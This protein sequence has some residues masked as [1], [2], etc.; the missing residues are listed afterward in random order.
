MT[1]YRDSHLARGE[2]YD[3]TLAGAPF[4]HYMAK[5]ERDYLL[6]TVPGLFPRGRP[7]Y[8]DFA[9]GTGRITQTV[10]PLAGEAI[11]VDISSSMLREAQRK[12][13]TVRFV[14]ADLTKAEVDLGIF[15]MITSF[16]F[17]GNAQDEL[18]VSVMRTLNRLLRPGGY[19][20]INSHRNPHSI[21]DILQRIGNANQGMD[22]HYFK[23]KRLLRKHG[24][25]IVKTRPIGA[26][27]YR[28]KLMDASYD[29]A[30]TKRLESMFTS[31]MFTPI[32]PD[33]VIVARKM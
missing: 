7:R 11:G 17:F 13:P 6:E 23:L 4:D 1:D 19:L 31:S 30:S 25:E 22:L 16:R 32:A 20:V 5:A 3:A 18:R 12:C 24:F 33:A 21:S 10:A 27:M 14:Q 26:W 29:S 15:D 28:A 2:S 9:C 8:L